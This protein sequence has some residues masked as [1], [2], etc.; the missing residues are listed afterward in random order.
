MISKEN[1]SGVIP[2]L[3]SRLNIALNVSYPACPQGDY[4]CG[5]LMMALAKTPLHK[6]IQGAGTLS[7]KFSSLFQRRQNAMALGRLSAV[8]KVDL[9]DSY[10]YDIG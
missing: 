2:N 8:T 6:E 3:V 10:E 1:Y 9:T 7:R 4:F 5:H